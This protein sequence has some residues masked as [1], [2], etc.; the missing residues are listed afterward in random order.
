FNILKY[1]RNTLADAARVEIDVP[2]A[3]NL[4][5]ADIDCTQGKVNAEQAQGLIA[6]AE[7]KYNESKGRLDKQD[8]DWEFFD[9]VAVLLAPFGVSPKP[10]Y[11]K[12]SGEKGIFYP[13]WIRAILSLDGRLKQDEDTFPYI[14]RAYL[15]PQVNQD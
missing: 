1:W 2:K 8:P 6:Q 12:L 3:I 14:P 13:F 9:E 10:E 4:L 5:E 7:K 11:T 15:E